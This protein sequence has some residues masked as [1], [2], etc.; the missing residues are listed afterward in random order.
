M[1]I[2]QVIEFSVRNLSGQEEKIKTTLSLNVQ[3]EKSTYLIHRALVKQLIEHRQGNANTKTKSEVN[4]GGRK[5][6]KQKGTGRARAGSIRSPL[7]KGGGVTFGPKKR[8]F[9]IKQIINDKKKKK[10]KKNLR[11][12]KI[13]YLESFKRISDCC[14]FE[15]NPESNSISSFGEK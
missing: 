10:K 11:E 15:E 9:K 7:W 6:W 8:E 4:G 13:V 5:P 1:L 2:N 3:N 12:R 14:A